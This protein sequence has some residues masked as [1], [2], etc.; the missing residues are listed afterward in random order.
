VWTGF[1]AAASLG[2]RLLAGCGFEA[3][4]AGVFAWGFLRSRH[5]WLEADC[6]FLA[7]RWW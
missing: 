4:P 1:G 3:G 6:G 7:V 2:T 5:G